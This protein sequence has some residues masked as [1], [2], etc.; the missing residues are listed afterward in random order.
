MNFKKELKNSKLNQVFSFLFSDNYSIFLKDTLFF[1]I[2]PKISNKKVSF[3]LALLSIFLLWY[4]RWIEKIV[5]FLANDFLP[6]ILLFLALM[7]LP[8]EDLK[9]K[10]HHLWFLGFLVS[11]ILAGFIGVF[12]FNSGFWIFMGWLVFLQFGVAMIIGE[13]LKEKKTFYASLVLI[14]L[15]L[16]FFGAMQAAFGGGMGYSYLETAGFRVTSFLGNPNIF[17]FILVVLMFL[18][19]ELFFRSENR[20][21]KNTIIAIALISLVLLYFTGSRTAWI[22]LVLGI[23]AYLLI[24]NYRLLLFFPLVFL[25]LVSERVRERFF[26]IFSPEYYQDSLVDGRLWSINNSFYIWQKNIFGT[27]PGTYGGRFARE[28]SS[29]VY[30]EGMQR[31][32]PALFTTDNQYLSILVQGGILGI[33]FFVGYFVSILVKLFSNKS[34]L[35]ISVLF[36][37]LVMMLLSNAL[38]FGA[39]AVLVGVVL[40]QELAEV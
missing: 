37:F 27:G 5:P 21:Q 28:H 31:G 6:P 39:V 12:K 25:A 4:E 36:S 16:L 23:F 17:G 38:E 29:A 7:L 14:S 13:A 11:L 10:K 18:C 32:Y 30:L 1:K 34:F 26:L 9:I 40:G 8:K 35:G 19:S 3:A 33:L 24:K 2:L 20:A 15:P 22:S